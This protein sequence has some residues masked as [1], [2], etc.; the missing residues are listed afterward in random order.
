MSTL[1]NVSIN[2]SG[3]AAQKNLNSDRPTM[4]IHALGSDAN[5]EAP[6]TR[7]GVKVDLSMEGLRAS[8]SSATS[9]SSSEANQAK[10]LQQIREQ[11]KELQQ[12]IQEQQAEMQAILANR[13]LSDEEKTRAVSTI[14]QQLANLNGSLASATAELLEAMQG[15]P[16][17]SGSDAVHP[18]P[19][20][21]HST[22]APSSQS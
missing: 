8:A 17:L 7:E 15:K 21:H 13:S 18:L 19:F 22:E 1:T 10:Q 2:H 20:V 11:I 16:K 3:T 12:Q 5:P 9:K 6:I 14:A 4:K